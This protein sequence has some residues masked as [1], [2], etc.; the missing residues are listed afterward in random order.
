MK[1]K[2]HNKPKRKKDYVF[3]M[4]LGIIIVCLLIV[5]SFVGVFE[6]DNE[7]ND[8]NKEEKTDKNEGLLNT[9]FN[10]WGSI[11]SLF[12]GGGGGECPVLNHYLNYYQ[13]RYQ[14]ENSTSNPPKIPNPQFTI[15]D[16]Y[17]SIDQYIYVSV[18]EAHGHEV[19]YRTN[20][21]LE[22]AAPLTSAE[23]DALFNGETVITEDKLE[24]ADILKIQEEMFPGVPLNYGVL[25]YLNGS[26][27][28]DSNN[29]STNDSSLQDY[30]QGKTIVQPTLG[31]PDY[32]TRFHFNYNTPAVR[33]YA[34][35]F[36]L[37]KI[38][39]SRSNSVFIDNQAVNPRQLFEDANPA[40]PLN[41]ISSGDWK[42]QT[43]IYV[44][45]SVY[46]YN[47]IKARGNNPKIIKNGLRI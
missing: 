25:L 43:R 17:D 20:A 23:L 33:E 22:T 44:N 35:R 13:L 16:A 7:I 38:S 9:L 1:N 10:F 28:L 30:Q 34:I 24:R 3:I 12:S 11:I 6:K 45:N 8:K 5:F 39:Q 21:D 42:E 47:Q 27:I 4:S 14:S 26:V 46:I 37:K 40:K 29:K 2:I 31:G 19:V 41:Y 36:A 32:L 15:G 18:A